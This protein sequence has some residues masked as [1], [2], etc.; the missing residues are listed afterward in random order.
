M[1]FQ[2]ATF[3][4]LFM[5]EYYCIVYTHHIFFTH[6]SVDGHL[7]YFCILTV[8]NSAAMNIEV[9]ASTWINS[10]FF[11]WSCCEACWIL[12][13]Q[14]GIKFMPTAVKVWSPNHWTTREFPTILH[15]KKKILHFLTTTTLKSSLKSSK[16]STYIQDFFHYYFPLAIPCTFGNFEEIVLNLQTDLR[17]L[18][19][20]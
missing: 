18:T 1:L 6:S 12:V 20:L 5:A 19:S 3:H 9:H 2:M 4:S 16:V 14:P 7:D 8:V 15:F 10:T 17:E 13:L 11:F